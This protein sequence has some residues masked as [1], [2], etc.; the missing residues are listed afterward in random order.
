MIGGGNDKKQV[1]YGDIDL[2][3]NNFSD[4]QNQW[5]STGKNRFTGFRI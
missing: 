3:L 5:V 1:N 4:K 2:K